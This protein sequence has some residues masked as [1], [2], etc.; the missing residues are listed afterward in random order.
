MLNWLAAAKKQR[1]SARSGQLFWALW[2]LGA[3]AA[4]DSQSKL[5]ER[6]RAFKQASSTEKSAAA[7][8]PAAPAPTAPASLQVSV[9]P[10]TGISLLI[11]GQKVADTSPFVQSGLAP[12]PHVLWVRAMGY[13]D[14]TLPLELLPGQQLS[15]PVALRPRVP[16][17]VAAGTGPSGSPPSAARQGPGPVGGTTAAPAS[18]NAQGAQGSAAGA[19]EL[20]Q[21]APL[22]PGTRPMLLQLT[23]E[24]AGPVLA[25][26][27]P[28]HPQSVR[29][30]QGTG[31]L[32]LAGVRLP[33]RI[34][35]GHVL[36]LQ[37]P[38]DSAAWFRDGSQVKATSLLRLEGRPMVLR[39]A[40]PTG[41]ILTATVRRLE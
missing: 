7:E 36:E 37:V 9:V 34:Y 8:K 2:A 29:L 19:Q 5:K 18:Q 21:P 15:V 35:P 12:G 6:V 30:A 1:R 17:Q 24:P 28:S 22:P 26:G 31:V 27:V 13:H 20:P 16:T 41:A 39:R 3:L 32:T 23:L 11:D 40:D 10:A 38:H 4:C 33:Y 14:V 25:D